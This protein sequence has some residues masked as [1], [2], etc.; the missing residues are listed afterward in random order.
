MNNVVDQILFL[1][2]ANINNTCLITIIPVES[3][4]DSEDGAAPVK[5]GR[6]R[7][8]GSTKKKNTNAM[9]PKSKGT[10]DS[11]DGAAPV[12]RGRGRPKGSTKKKNTN[13]MKPKSKGT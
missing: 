13:A 8:K 11:E 7:P 4:G 9:K 2:E 12:K 10:G 6:G 3:A 5:R 1:M